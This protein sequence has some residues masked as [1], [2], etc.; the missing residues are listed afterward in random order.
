MPYAIVVKKRRRIKD[1]VKNWKLKKKLNRK[2]KPDEI[3][4]LEYE[5]VKYVSLIGFRSSRKCDV[6]TTMFKN[7]AIFYL[8]EDFPYIER[9]MGNK[10][11]TII[12]VKT[13]QDINKQLP[14][15]ITVT[16][17][18]ETVGDVKLFKIN[19]LCL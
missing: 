13:D 17:Q 8:E 3:Q 1:A 18:P 15:E 12:D 11:Y 4:Y 9:V 5:S 2:L 19:E 10:P 6:R 14:A 7:D 16:K